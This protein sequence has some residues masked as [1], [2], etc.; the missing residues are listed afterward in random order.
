MFAAERKVGVLSDFCLEAFV[1]SRD[2]YLASV[3]HSGGGIY[4]T[5]R[6]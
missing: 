4:F 3:R 5:E 6:E 1:A 2:Q